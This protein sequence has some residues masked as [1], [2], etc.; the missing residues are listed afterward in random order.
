MRREYNHELQVEHRAIGGGYEIEREEM[1][2]LDHRKVLYVV[3][4]GV[5]DTSCCGVGGCHFAYVPGFVLQFKIRRNHHDQWVSEVEPI[6]E[7]ET[8]R[9]ISRLIEEKESVQQV[10]FG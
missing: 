2:D 7:P 1:L 10:N 6:T 9:R 3:G 8:R 4:T 5:M